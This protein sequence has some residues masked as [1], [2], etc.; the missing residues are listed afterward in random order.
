M[1]GRAAL[2]KALVVEA[3]KETVELFHQYWSAEKNNLPMYPDVRVRID[4]H[5]KSIPIA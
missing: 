4:K 2:P 5:L 1:A 3:A